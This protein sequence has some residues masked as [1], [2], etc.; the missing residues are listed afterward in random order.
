MKKTCVVSGIGLSLL[1]QRQQV[2][3]CSH[4]PSQFQLPLKQACD[5]PAVSGCIA[6]LP[7]TGTASLLQLQRKCCWL[8][9]YTGSALTYECWETWVQ[10]C[11]V[12][13]LMVM[14]VLIC[15]VHII[16]IKL[17]I[18]FSLKVCEMTVM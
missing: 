14:W 7:V 17:F 8:K 2:F 18:S 16:L 9:G 1:C 5:N 13:K 12:M 15:L 4:D 11:V 6:A 3:S 10:K